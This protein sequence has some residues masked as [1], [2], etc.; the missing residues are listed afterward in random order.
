MA[1][2]GPV[3]FAVAAGPRLGF[4]HLLRSRSLARALDVPWQVYLRGTRGTHQAA[5][6]L[7]ARLLPQAGGRID[8]RLLVVDDPSPREAARWVACA[9]RAQVPVATVHDLGLGEVASDLI[10]DGS[11]HQSPARRHGPALRGPAYAILD[12][13]IAVTRMTPAASARVLI[14]LGGGAHVRRLAAGLCAALGERRPDL[15]IRVA[16]G[17]T[18]VC[19]ATLPLGRWI[20]VPDG[21]ADE[22]A[23]ATVAIVAGGVTLSEACALGVPAVGVAVTDA[24]QLTVRAL[25]RVGAVVDGGRLRPD[26]RCLRTVADHTV[27]LLSAAA[28]RR[29]LSRTASRLIDGHGAHRVAARLRAMMTGGSRQEYAHAG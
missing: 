21:L 2:G 19:A 15:D 26:P 3:V 17:F 18:A 28:R 10:V 5:R 4:G 20:D 14:T 13:A 24:Q 9:R 6:R 8:A 11:V 7:G 12:P 22:L 23:H 1:R 16:G 27:E 25:A 29:Q